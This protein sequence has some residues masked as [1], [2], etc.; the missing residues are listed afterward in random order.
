MAPRS[1][2]TRRWAG[3]AS[4][5]RTPTLPPGVASPQCAAI[6]SSPGHNSVHLVVVRRT[7]F[8]KYKC[9]LSENVS[10]RGCGGRSCRRGCQRG[11]RRGFPSQ[12][13]RS[14]LP[15][16]LSTSLAIIAMYMSPCRSTCTRPGLP[17][18]GCR[19][20]SCFRAIRPA[21]FRSPPPHL[22]TSCRSTC[23]AAHGIPSRC[24]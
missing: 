21:A 14:T 16:R 2:S 3:F 12:S 11:C 22:L 4:T 17:A 9:P 19:C 13:I 1:G 15:P 7:V 10:P 24:S 23:P 6:H 20:G 5:N 18:G 8:A